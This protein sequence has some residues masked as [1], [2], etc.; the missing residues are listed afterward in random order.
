MLYRV[1]RAN[2]IYC[3][4]TNQTL[5][6]P[7][8][9]LWQSHHIKKLHLSVHYHIKNTWLLLW[10]QNAGC[11]QF[12]CPW[13]DNHSSWLLTG[14]LFIKVITEGWYTSTVWILSSRSVDDHLAA[15]VTS[16]FFSFSLMGTQLL[17]SNNWNWNCSLRQENTSLWGETRFFSA[18][19]Q[20]K[21][22]EFLN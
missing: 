19:G 17:T 11:L 10:F 22:I 4:F 8:L 3:S 15:Q 1:L 6:V 14:L 20:R 18:H 21:N 5:K 16:V 2:A 12:Y 9:L 7:F 13:S